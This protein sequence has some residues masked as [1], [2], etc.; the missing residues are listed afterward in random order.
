[1]SPPSRPRSG[2]VR[3]A[4]VRQAH[5]SL[6]GLWTALVLATLSFTPSLLPRPSAFQGLVAA[7][8]GA[9]G[10]GLGVLGAW[11]WREF[12]DRDPREP[13]PRQWRVLAGVAAV[14]LLVATLVGRHWQQQLRGLND[15]GGE[16]WPS[17]VLVPVVGT[18]AFVL[19][20]GG[21]RG[22]R[23]LGRRWSS[24]LGR[25]MGDRAAR[26][27]GLV[28]LSLA[29]LLAV[30]GLL[31][32]ALLKAF[33]QA[34]AVADARTPEGAE[35][36]TSTL[37]SGSP[38]SL[39][40][41][42]TLG[43]RGK[44]FVSSGPSAAQITAWSGE[45]ALEPVRAY[46]SIDTEPDLADR[47]QL[48]VDDL[49]RAGGFQRSSLLVV[50]T[51]GTGWVEPSASDSFEYLTGGDSAIASMQYSYQPSWLSYL[52]DPDVAGA[53][54]RALFDAVY[55]R[56]AQLPSDSRP[57]LYVFGESLGSFG[58]ETAFSGVGDLA[59]R[60]DGALLVGPPSFN[61]LYP[62]LTDHR[63][64]GSPQI[65][66]VFRDGEVVRF[67]RRPAT[68][69]P[70]VGTPWP[71]SRVLYLLN[72]SDPITWWSPDLLL[73]R[74]DWLEE[75][76]GAEVLDAMHWLPLVTF[77]QTSVDLAMAFSMPPGRGH[78]FT[79]EHVDGWAAVLDVQ[80]WDR[81]RSDSLR[82]IIIANAG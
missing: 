20:V 51:T 4:V 39:V 25:R 18:V 59:N 12:A 47:A 42:D 69:V 40:D 19:L 78:N 43:Y 1:M 82:A 27:L 31:G 75:E 30:T 5:G 28:S 57:R 70:P 61:T 80:G 16:P 9:L 36:P 37:R 79:G 22:L 46:A 53:A 6:P 50:T 17:L 34:A 55:A 62:Q 23:S 71:G 52:V 60:V 48:V 65:E 10:Y 35:Q 41:W 45:P 74:P 14:L 77:W 13:S 56:W 33:D 72:P 7:V 81:E 58:T 15:L 68:S 11:V 64:A 63:D 26:A 8:T 3:D 38:D 54:S 21:A 24:W 29:V 66:P 49:E 32:D 67:S 2:V 76:R 73:T 44:G